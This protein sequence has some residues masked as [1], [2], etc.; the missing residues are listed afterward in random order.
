M[1][2]ERRCGPGKHV[3]SIRDWNQAQREYYDATASEYG[4]SFEQ[5][6]AFFRLLLDH[7]LRAL[8]LSPGE[9][10]LEL[11]ASGGRFTIP[12]AEQNCQV[13]GVD[14]STKSLGY[15]RKILETHPQ[16]NRVELIEDDA[17]E[18][19]RLRGREFD[20]VTAAHFLHHVEDAHKVFAAVLRLLRP[21]GKVVF[22]EP[23][24]ANPLWYIQNT[25]C[26]NRQWRIEKGL[27]GAWR[28]RL[29]R[30]L[31]SANFVNCE[32]ST[33]GFLPPQI[34]NCEPRL[35]ILE[36]LAEHS[37]LAPVLLINLFQARKP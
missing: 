26:P 18:L 33:F 7:Y 16:R 37:F 22:L 24:P 29:L 30:K 1:P 31:R 2:T 15:L 36:S 21:G 14:V 6:G 3:V 4:G 5:S 28:W 27:L 8:S 11:G 12:L 23:N 13:T 10:V 32:A 25:F 34:L 17:T 20:V 35:R 9:R 19:S